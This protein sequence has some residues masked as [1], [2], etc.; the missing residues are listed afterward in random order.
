[1]LARTIDRISVAVLLLL[2]LGGPSLAH[3]LSGTVYGDGTPMPNATVLLI[4]AATADELGSTITDAQG[5]YSFSVAD[6][7]YDLR[8]TPPIESEEY[9]DSLV[10]GIAVSGANVEQHIL[11]VPI[12]YSVSGFVRL[13]DG[14]PVKGIKVNI[15]E[16]DTGTLTDSVTTG[17]DGFYSASV[18]PG[19]YKFRL[20]GATYDGMSFP[21]CPRVLNVGNAQNSE[22]YQHTSISDDT[23]QDFS[24]PL[25]YLS[26][27]T[28]D[29][30]GVPVSQVALQGSNSL[31]ID[32]VFYAVGVSLVS[33]LDGNF[34]TALPTHSGY[35]FTAIPPEESGFSRSDIVNHE[36][37]DDSFLHIILQIPD[38]DGPIIVAG[39]YITDITDQTAS[40]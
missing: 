22:L 26:G 13:T 19:T 17:D 10:N 28:T 5:A 12:G 27:Q 4:N 38:A 31:Y 1:M 36:I 25:V 30:N 39:P 3:T 7:T 9:T 11:L 6:G 15:M 21:D 8:V 16:Q 40:V 24:L 37:L 34:R 35:E 14:T 18:S 2:V 32:G 20:Y 23:V 33:D 29:S